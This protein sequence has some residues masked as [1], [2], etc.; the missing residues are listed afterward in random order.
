MLF[1]SVF[2][3]KQVMPTRQLGY[4]VH[5]NRQTIYMNDHDGLGTARDLGGNQR[6]VD[7]PSFASTVDN[8]WDGARSDNGSG[9]G[10]DR[11]ARKNN[12]VAR[13]DAQRRERHF[14]RGAAVAHGDA[15]RAAHQSRESSFDF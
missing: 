2:N 15:V 5:I 4:W 6:G 11:E 1:G 10:N 9:A 3:D 8:D 12:L 14:D 13:S 7:V